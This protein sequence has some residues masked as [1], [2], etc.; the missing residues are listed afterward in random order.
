L[1]VIRVISG[2][3]ELSALDY[4]KHYKMPV[5]YLLD[6][7]RAFERK[8][9]RD[10]WPFLMLVDPNGQVVYKCNNLVDREKELMQQ[11]REFGKESFPAETKMADGIPYMT[12]TLQRSDEDKKPLQN[13]RFTSIAAGADGKIYAVFTSLKNGNNDIVLRICNDESSDKDIPIAATDADEYD[14]TVLLDNKNQAWICWTSNAVNNKYQ[15]HLTSLEDVRDGR[16]SIVVSKS[17]DDAM[18][19]R[20]AADDSGALWITY[21][22]WQNIGQNSRDKEVY[23]RKYSN[24][25]FSEEIHISPSDVPSYEDHTDPSISVLNG[26]VFVSWSWDFHRPKGYPQD[27]RE[28][29]IFTRTVSN[30]FAMGQ[31]FHLSGR[32]IDTAPALSKAHNNTLWCAWDSLGFRGRVCRKTFYVRPFSASDEIGKEFAVAGNLMNVC[33]PCFAF[34]AGRKGV[35]TFSQTENGKDWSLWKAEY[36]SDSNCWTEPAMIISD[37]NPRFGSCVYDSR[38][39]LWIAYSVQTDK[40]RE[41]AVKQVD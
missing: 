37:G 1:Q 16:K 13:D 36:D 32:W 11:I 14:G 10:G 23:L 25:T 9:N 26:Q 19:G 27:A 22:Q 21:Y 28:P 30:D 40:G 6:S 39:R 24:G 18:H 4:Q 7:D 34:D 35:L 5:V 8:H 33:S 20:M 29:T 3:N 31:P 41:V 2:D 38:G 15:I 12:S 17:K